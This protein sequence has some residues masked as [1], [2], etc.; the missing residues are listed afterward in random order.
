MHALVAVRQSDPAQLDH[1]RVE[2]GL[3]GVNERRP[4]QE[5]AQDFGLLSERK[6]QVVV[7]VGLVEPDIS[8]VLQVIGQSGNVCFGK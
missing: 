2:R 1:A 6:K 5:H 4:V 3:V 8:A 7:G